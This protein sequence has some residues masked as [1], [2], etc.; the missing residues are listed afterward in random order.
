MP[1]MRWPQLPLR[2]N[3]PR[4]NHLLVDWCGPGVVGYLG[5]RQNDPNTFICAMNERGSID[6]FIDSILDRARTEVDARVNAMISRQINTLLSY[7]IRELLRAIGGDSLAQALPP[8]FE[9]S[10]LYDRIFQM[11]REQ[12]LALKIELINRVQ[13]EINRTLRQTLENI[14]NTLCAAGLAFSAN[15]ILKQLKENLKNMIPVVEAGVVMAV[16]RAA[17]DSLMR[18]VRN[19]FDEWGMAIVGVLVAALV[20]LAIAVLVL[21]D[22]TGLGVLDDVLIAPLAAILRQAVTWMGPIIRGLGQLAEGLDGLT[23]ALP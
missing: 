20:A 16:A 18:S 17:V 3:D 13:A 22:S 12:I 11:I 6:R 23:P 19:F 5:V 15:A 21:D 1:T 14:M 2:L 7:S 4:G 10:P 9:N 8:D